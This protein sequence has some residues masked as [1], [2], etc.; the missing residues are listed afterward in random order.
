MARLFMI[1]LLCCIA[2]LCMA[3]EIEGSNYVTI[4]GTVKDKDSKKALANVSISLDG[5]NIGTVSNNDG[6]FSLTVPV[7]VEYS[8]G[9]IKAEQLGYFLCYYFIIVLQFNYRT[10]VYCEFNEQKCKTHLFE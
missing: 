3:T 5:S 10:M 7:P 9:N 6:A 2:A 4:S 1:K 8:N